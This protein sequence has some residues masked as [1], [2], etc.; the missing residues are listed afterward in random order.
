MPQLHLSNK[1]LTQLKIQDIKQ[2]IKHRINH[3][4]SWIVLINLAVAACSRLP[5]NA[6]AIIKPQE[7]KQSTNLALT[8][9]I[10]PT[11]KEN[12]STELPVQYIDPTPTKVPPIVRTWGDYPGPTIY[13]PIEIPPPMPLLD[14]SPSQTNILLLGDDQR[15]YES[16]LRTD[17]IILVSIDTNKNLIILLS[18]PRDLYVYAPGWT[19]QRINVI[20][21]RGGFD[22]LS[23]TF[24]YNFGIKLDYYVRIN[25]FALEKLIDH[26]GGIDVNV[27]YTMTDYDPM[28]RGNRTILAGKIHMN[29]AVATWYCRARYAT[30]DFDRAR[31]QQEVLLAVFQRLIRTDLVREA[32]EMYHQ[33]SS[34]VS[35]NMTFENIAQYIPFIIKNKEKLPI[36]QYH[37]GSSFVKEWTVPTDGSKVLL[38]KR[39]PIRL[40][41][42]QALEL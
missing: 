13:P 19:M 20:Y 41:M 3:L 31:R 10:S 16:G 34:I 38:P 35:T 33:L 26:L 32:P 39:D 22:L 6:D 14:K 40:L 42:L 30:S 21:Q 36:R 18:F 4:F 7:N 29:G 25:I 23:L 28:L 12:K 5:L 2:M 37:I 27:A 1:T 11:S 17:G 9:L 15:P 24:A 8:P